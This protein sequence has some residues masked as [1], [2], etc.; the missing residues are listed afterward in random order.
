MTS[1]SD[2]G[3]HAADKVSA[4]ASDAQKSLAAWGA[5]ARRVARNNPAAVLIGSVA[6]GFVLA[7]VARHA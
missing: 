6:L 1:K 3:A 2:V 4:R 5:R 7:R